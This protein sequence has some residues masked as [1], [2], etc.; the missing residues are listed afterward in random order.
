MISTYLTGVSVYSMYGWASSGR[1]T[2]DE[3]AH[4]AWVEFAYG[5]MSFMFVT[6][7]CVAAYQK[8][9]RMPPAQP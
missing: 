1:C 4:L 2:F 8:L 6:V 9:R 5:P 7:L 3:V